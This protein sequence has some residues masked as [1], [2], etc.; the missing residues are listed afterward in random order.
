MDDLLQL[1]WF[2]DAQRELVRELHARAG[3]ERWLDPG[4]DDAAA[5]RAALG[6]LGRWGYLRLTVSEPWNLTN[7]VLAREALAYHCGIADLA[8][9][10]QALGA[11]PIL[12]MGSE[13]T[14]AVLLPKVASGE[15][16]MAFA[17]SEPEAGSDVAALTTTAR[18]E[19]QGGYRIQGCKHLISNAGVAD[20]YT[21]FARTGEGKKGISAF[22][23][24]AR[25]PGVEIERQ[26]PSAPHPLGIVRFA[27]VA[28]PS[29]ALLGAE[30]DGLKLALMTLERCRT[31]VGAAAC[32]F[33]RRALDEA[34]KHCR[35]R[36]MFGSTLSE[37]P[38]AQA[39]LAEMQARLEASRLLVY[40]AAWAY[41]QSAGRTRI[42]RQAAVAKWQATENAQWIIDQ[43]LQ[44]AGGLGVLQGSIFERLYREIRPL[45]IY[46]G[47]SEVQ[48][49]VIA[50]ELLSSPAAAPQEPLP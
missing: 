9:V 30:G 21:V 15:A 35:G 32:G 41:D 49:L 50:R 16:C 43:A 25:A 31:T 44:L 36:R 37:Q 3:A 11:L 34:L 6:A 22:V 28:V 7:N 29:S 19:A 20:Y 14:K 18:R 12:L 40:R 13:A 33:A 17:L 45:R 26:V 38:L 48:Q 5:L 8:F 42:T 1:P 46:E 39:R 24:H 10:M 4:I 47:A 27:D 23:V 2:S